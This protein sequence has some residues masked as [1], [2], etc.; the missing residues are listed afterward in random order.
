MS[1]GSRRCRCN[2]TSPGTAAKRE[3]AVLLYYMFLKPV[4]LPAGEAAG[5]GLLLSSW[6]LRSRTV[7]EWPFSLARSPSELQDGIPGPSDQPERGCRAPVAFSSFRVIV[8]PLHCKQSRPSLFL[9]AL[10]QTL[11]SWKET[12]HPGKDPG[13]PGNQVHRLNP[14]SA[15]TMG[16]MSTSRQLNFQTV[17]TKMPIF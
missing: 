3:Q 6:G 5:E 17:R 1:L 8:F 9:C 2:C 13:N 7:E 15:T 10:Y 11:C 12:Q 14:A 16:S 4:L